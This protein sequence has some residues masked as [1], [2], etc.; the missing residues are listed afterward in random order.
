MKQKLYNWIYRV[1]RRLG[2]TSTEHLNLNDAFER[3]KA[4]QSDDHV[5]AVS[6]LLI[7]HPHIQM[8]KAIWN[9]NN[10]LESFRGESFEESFNKY[11]VAKTTASKSIEKSIEI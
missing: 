7:W 2:I 9:C 3:V 1:L 11:R 10:S 6:V 5:C 8:K 4:L